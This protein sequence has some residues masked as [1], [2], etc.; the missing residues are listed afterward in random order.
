M[1]I[2]SVLFALFATV[3]LWFGSSGVVLADIPPPRLDGPTTV[4][5]YLYLEDVNDIRLDT[6]TFDATAQLVLK[7]KDERLAFSSPDDTP[8][9][10]MGVRAERHLE[11]IWHPVLDISGEKGLSSAVVYALTVHPD[12]TVV[13]RQ[14]FTTRPRFIG[15]LIWFP[16]GRLM[17]DLNISSMAVDA[18]HMQFELGQLAPSDSMESLD[19]VLHGN[20]HPVRMAWVTRTVEYPDLPGKAFPQISL[21]IEVVHDFI[22]GVHKVLLP[23]LIIAL[24]SWGLMWVNFTVQPAFSSPRIAGI[25]TLILTSIALKFVLNR[26]LPVVHYLTFSDV[27]FNTT[28]MMLSF[29]MLASCVVASLFTDFSVPR[30]QWLHRWLRGIY[31]VLYVVVLVVSCVLF[32]A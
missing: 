23:L 25:I 9:S 8:R 26:E 10:W 30:A 14:K 15:E 1:R 12:G 20:W 6:G 24:A 18:R 4:R 22:D 29:G 32:L 5:A 28:I 21:Q 11:K 3:L 16:F 17:L 2:K 19:T 31:P 7:W 27:L 13:T